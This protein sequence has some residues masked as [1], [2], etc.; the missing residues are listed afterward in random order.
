MYQKTDLINTHDPLLIPPASLI[1]GAQQESIDYTIRY[2]QQLLCLYHGCKTCFTC[3]SVARQAHHQMLWINPEQR[4]TL[5]TI[6]AI[7]H[8][9]TLSLDDDIHF[10]FVLNQA[11]TLSLACANSLLKLVEEPPAGYHF[12]FLAQRVEE[13]LPTIKSRCIIT[14]LHSNSTDFEQ[15]PLIP[16]FTHTQNSDPLLFLKALEQ[17]KISE[18]DCPQFLDTL[19]NY[20]TSLY[21]KNIGQNQTYNVIELLKNTL[22]TPSM[23]GSVKLFLKNLYLNIHYIVHK[24]A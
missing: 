14:L 3:S 18:Q 7:R 11:D 19:F 5:E 24:K 16:F 10:F 8:T 13:V 1:V 9:I 22:S 12:I 20:W 21:K 2:I 23:T 17:S 15:H 4:Y 6:D